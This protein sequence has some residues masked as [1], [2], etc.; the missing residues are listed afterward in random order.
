MWAWSCQGSLVVGTFVFLFFTPSLIYVPIFV[1]NRIF[2]KFG[3]CSVVVV[4][5]GGVS[6]GVDGGDGVVVHCSQIQYPIVPI[7]LAYSSYCTC[8]L[9]LTVSDLFPLKLKNN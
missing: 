7:V 1:E 3:G 5:G 9:F 4:G 6:D 2:L 8:L